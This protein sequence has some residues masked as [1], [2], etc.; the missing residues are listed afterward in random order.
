MSEQPNIVP[1]G[2]YER[3]RSIEEVLV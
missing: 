1:F 3:G 2:K